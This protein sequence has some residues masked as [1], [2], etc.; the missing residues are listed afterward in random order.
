MNTED[1]TRSSG[2]L[3]LNA[4][5]PAPGN[6]YLTVAQAANRLQLTRDTL[7]RWR[8]NGTGPMFRYHGGRIVYHI[9]DLDAWSDDNRQTQARKRKQGAPS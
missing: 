4:D 3:S 1:Q 9:E 7:D 6:P 8:M 5:A 2:E